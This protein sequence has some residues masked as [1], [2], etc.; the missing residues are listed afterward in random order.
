[1]AARATR[2]LYSLTVSGVVL[3]IAVASGFYAPLGD[4]LGRTRVMVGA[5][6]VL[7]LPKLACAAAPSF[8]ALVALRVAQGLLIPGVSALSVA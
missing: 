8:G 3:A 4:A 1:M 7:A 6:A 2:A 5:S